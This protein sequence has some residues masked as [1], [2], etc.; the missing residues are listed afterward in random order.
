MGPTLARMARRAA[1]DS[2]PRDRRVALVVGR[3]RERRSNEAGVE[4]VSL[5]SA[6]PR[7]RDDAA[8]RAERDLHGRPEVRNDRRAGDDVGD[9]HDRPGELRRA[10]S[11]LAHRRV[12]DGQRV[13]AHAGRVRRIARDRPARRRSASTR[14][15]ASAASECSS[16]TP[17][18]TERAS[19]SCDSTTRSICAT[20]CSSTSRREVKRGEPV[21]VDM[22][23]V[24]VIWQ[25]DANRIA[26]ECLP[27]AGD[28][29]VR[30]QRDGR[31]DVCPFATLADVVRRALRKAPRSSPASSEP[32]RC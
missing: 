2:S 3:A 31:R 28:A 15:R 5:R 29:A 9:E 26:L 21:S 30:R 18:A 1:R 22:G 13:R 4:T 17:S 12:L 10:L 7:R 27:L 8:R 25:G 32:T 11:R 20:A 14:R 19:R 6:R 23:Y 16:S 24:N